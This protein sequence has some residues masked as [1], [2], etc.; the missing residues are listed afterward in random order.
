MCGKT[1][2]AHMSKWNVKKGAFHAYYPPETMCCF[3]AFLCNPMY[4][5]IT[6]I[7]LYLV[8]C[9]RILLVFSRMY[10]YLLVC[11]SYVLVCYS[12]VLVCFSYVLVCT[13]KLLVWVVVLHEPTASPSQP[14]VTSRPRV[15]H[16]SSQF[17][18]NSVP[19]KILNIKR[20]YSWI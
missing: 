19:K 13:L 15:N 9:C 11:Y 14:R 10:S 20:T 8:V 16:E 12:Y 2:P 17:F 5:Y 4:S 6:F 1:W 3:Y 18:L 7:L